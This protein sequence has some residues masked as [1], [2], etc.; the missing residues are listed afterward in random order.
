MKKGFLRVKAIFQIIVFV[1]SIFSVYLLNA[2]EV[3]AQE[4]NVCCAKT[5]SDEYC[6]YTEESNCDVDY[7]S[8]N[9]ASTCDQTSYCEPVCC[10]NDETGECSSNVGAGTCQAEGLDYFSQ[11]DCSISECQKGCCE[12]GT[13]FIFTTEQNCV[14]ETSKFPD[15]SVNFDNGIDNEADCLKEQE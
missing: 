15:L 8:D 4:Q 10:Y 12:I 13:N 7:F 1:M 2:K 6:I 3:K 11:A 9:L 5:N 14:Y